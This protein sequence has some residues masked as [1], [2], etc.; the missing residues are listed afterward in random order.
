MDILKSYYELCEKDIERAC[1]ESLSLLDDDEAFE[2][3]C[4]ESLKQDLNF[5]QKIDI[6]QLTEEQQIE[7][8]CKESLNSKRNNDNLTKIFTNTLK[9]KDIK[10]RYYRKKSDTKSRDTKSSDTKSRDKRIVSSK[11]I[12]RNLPLEKFNDMIDL[13]Y[14]KFKTSCCNNYHHLR[15]THNEEE[16]HQI[17]AKEWKNNTSKIKCLYCDTEQ[18]MTKTCKNCNNILATHLCK[19]C[20]VLSLSNDIIHCSKCNKC[21][22]DESVLIYCSKCKMCV[23]KPHN[24]YICMKFTKTIDMDCCICMRNIT[25]NGSPMGKKDS[26]NYIVLLECCKNVIH[27]NCLDELKKT[28][29]K[30]PYCR[31]ESI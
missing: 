4:E 23:H 5:S 1:A 15:I 12:K 10:K 14:A 24:K 16:N 31:K 27:K 6:S 28:S 19:I 2:K 9:N 20:H 13:A 22:V 17:D 29:D 7:L 8:A 26:S 3:A 21:H 30:C 25:F 18:P 11:N